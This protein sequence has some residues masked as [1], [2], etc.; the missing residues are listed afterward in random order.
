[1]SE[2]HVAQRD[3][4]RTIIDNF[5]PGQGEGTCEAPGP[6]PKHKDNPKHVTKWFVNPSPA[7]S[8]NP[9]TGAWSYSISWTYELDIPHNAPF[10][11]GLVGNPHEDAQYASVRF[12]GRIPSE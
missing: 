11:D 4:I 1:M 9:Q 12:D 10:A 8:W 7:E 5:S 6:K 3:G 2:V